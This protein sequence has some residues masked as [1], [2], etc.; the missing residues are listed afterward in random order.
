LKT[1]SVINEL[2]HKKKNQRKILPSY[3]VLAT[4][5][6]RNNNNEICSLKTNQTN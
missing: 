2:L 6:F 3:S 4:E 5:K 1:S